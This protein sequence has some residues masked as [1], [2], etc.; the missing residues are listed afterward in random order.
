MVW[1][2]M[3]SALDVLKGN[4]LKVMG[5]VILCYVIRVLLGTSRSSWNITGD[6]FSMSPMVFA[7]SE[8][9]T[10]IIIGAF[11]NS[12][13]F[14]TVIDVLSKLKTKERKN[15]F[16]SFLYAFKNPS[17]L[18]KGFIIH[19]INAVLLFLTVILYII[20]F[21]FLL[22]VFME[23]FSSESIVRFG[24][25]LLPSVVCLWVFLGLSQ[26]MYLLYED[27]KT[28]IFNCIRR[29]FRMMKGH[30]LSLIGLY[31]IFL[32]VHSVGLMA[33]VVGLF[34][35]ISFYEVTRLEYFHGLK[36]KERQREWKKN[37]E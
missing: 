27:P 5:I 13:L 34:V 25:I 35:T 36:Q 18:Y 9:I 30:R 8:N 15:L 2:S 6:G 23:G 14:F 32:F 16:S 26:A 20:S 29:S 21:L 37:F 1:S 33:L 4:W 12:I 10:A 3:S 24:G 11:F 22:N 7:T 17:L 28:S 31:I 19:A